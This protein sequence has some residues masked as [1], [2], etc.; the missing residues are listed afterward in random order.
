MKNCI[1]CRIIAGESPA[2]IIHE[3]EHLLVFHDIQ[4]QAPVH[5][6]LVPKKHLASIQ[7]LTPADKE[8]MGHLLYTAS[9]VA[10]NLGLQQNG[11]RLV[12]NDG[13]Y[14]G[15]AVFHLHLHLLG[16]R[17]MHWPPG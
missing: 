17:P 10:K 5:L 15:Q 14:G 13:R 3:D 6:L 2:R 16:G 12:I 9:S 7:D 4:P 8:L 11:Y 1:F